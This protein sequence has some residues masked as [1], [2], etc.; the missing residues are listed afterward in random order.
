[1]EKKIGK[2]FKKWPRGFDRIAIL[3]AMPM[4]VL[5]FNYSSE[6]YKKIKMVTISLTEKE[7][8]DLQNKYLA[9]LDKEPDIFDVIEMEHFY[10]FPNSK[11]IIA[12][13]QKE[14]SKIKN[15]DINLKNSLDRA[16]KEGGD[17]QG[18]LIE[19]NS[20]ISLIPSK[21]K[22]F[23]I[24]IT[25]ALAFVISTIIFIGLSIR[26]IPAIFKW[27]KEGFKDVYKNI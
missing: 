11:G 17:P 7:K 15:K 16:I 9:S 14:L 10:G 23:F 3:L 2:I 24:G 22:C 27:I 25:G 21:P 19:K 13:G 8:S 20:E 12:N 5:G 18:L 26:I 4:A 6:H 1:M